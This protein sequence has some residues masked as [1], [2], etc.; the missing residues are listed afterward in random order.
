MIFGN[1]GDLPV[2]GEDEEHSNSRRGQLHLKIGHGGPEDL[3]VLHQADVA[4]RDFQWADEE[5]LPHKQERQQASPGA[6]SEPFSYEDVGAAGG[7]K[8]R[9]ELR[10]HESVG[11]GD[12]DAD[13]PG[14]VRLGTSE[15]GQ[16]QR[17][18]DERTDADHVGHVD[19]GRVQHAQTTM[20]SGFFAFGHDRAGY[21]ISVSAG[22]RQKRMSARTGLHYGEWRNHHANANRLFNSGADRDRRVGSFHRDATQF[23]PSC[24]R[25]S[26]WGRSSTGRWQTAHHLLRSA[27]RRCGV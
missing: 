22:E 9:P 14:Q 16:D 25:G 17:D 20:K 19:R 23:P 5:Q 6:W 21:H 26:Q 8:S 1:V 3:E 18:C 27:S 4:A 15:C 10:D 7:R 2:E 13:Q 12:E 11:K 24:G